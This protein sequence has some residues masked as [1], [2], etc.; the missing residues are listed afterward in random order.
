MIPHI[1]A[2]ILFLILILV[3]LIWRTL[4]ASVK[5]MLDMSKQKSPPEKVQ[6]SNSLEPLEDD[7]EPMN[8]DDAD[9]TSISS[10]DMLSNLENIRNTDTMD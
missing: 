9:Y 3:F 8:P 6:G 5:K 4:Q 7:P 2:F 1:M 10:L